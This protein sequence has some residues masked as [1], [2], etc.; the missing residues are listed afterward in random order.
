MK[1]IR[2][3]LAIVASALAGLTACGGGADSRQE[4]A[5]TVELP[6][7]MTL[8]AWQLS[9]GA[10]SP[11][12]TAPSLTQ[13]ER[14]EVARSSRNHALE[15]LRE[16]NTSF[17]DNA[18]TIPPLHF[19]AVAVVEAAARGETLTQ[20]QSLFP[21]ATSVAAAHALSAGITRVVLV[22]KSTKLEGSLLA[23]LEG[24]AHA[25]FWL[26]QDGREVGDWQATSYHRDTRLVVADGLS[27]EWIWSDAAE[28]YGIWAITADGP[29]AI[30]PMLRLT[31]NVKAM[32][33]SGFDAFALRGEADRRLIAIRPTDSIVFFTRGQ[34]D[35]AVS[36]VTASF[37]PAVWAKRAD[38]SL[39]LPRNA[40]V[41]AARVR[42]DVNA[43]A[44]DEVRA[45]FGAIDGGGTYLSDSGFGS[46]LK[47]SAAGLSAGGSRG[48]EFIYSPRN[49]FGAGNVTGTGVVISLAPDP[50]W[51]GPCPTAP[52][53]LRPFFLLE[54]DA[55]DRVVWLARLAALDAI[56]CG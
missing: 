33:G 43:W 55:N 44:F 7:K 1:H 25:P 31:A 49:Q 20:W 56:R 27:R 30:V 23:A 21:P 8:G 11:S 17:P 32:S 51:P 16:V 42:F 39:V 9:R 5:V 15:T 29:R 47:I 24:P 52:P 12:G 36:E 22:D 34:L 46:T 54:L 50:G 28:F 40:I 48:L 53:D 10:A 19:A 4:A 41:I 35:A 38:A 6:S 26:R 18:L 14:E 13:S 45:N 2:R 37:S 3:A